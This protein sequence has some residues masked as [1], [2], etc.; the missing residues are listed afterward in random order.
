MTKIPN[1]IVFSYA[2]P[3]WYHFDCKSLTIYLGFWSCTSMKAYHDN[4]F[5]ISVLDLDIL[6]HDM[7]PDI[8]RMKAYFVSWH[9]RG[10]NLCPL[11]MYT[12]EKQKLS[13]H[14]FF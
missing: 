5:C 12:E 7:K 10:P 11:I 13:E 2:K 9:Q 6:F 4:Q 3:C 1:L 14:G 8:Q